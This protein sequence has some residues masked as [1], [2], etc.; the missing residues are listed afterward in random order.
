MNRRRARKA[1]GALFGVMAMVCGFHLY[2]QQTEADV[3]GAA[4]GG[5]FTV[6]DVPGA[7]TGFLEGTFALGINPAGAITGYYQD[8]DF[9]YHGF[10]RAADGTITTFDAPDDVGG[11]F[12]QGINPA[13]T[14]T[15]YYQDADF[16]GHGFLRSP[17]GVITTFDPPGSIFTS[18]ISINPAGAITGNYEDEKT[19]IHGFLRAP[20]GT[21]TTFD[22]P[23]AGTG[24]L[25]GTYASGINPWGEISGC[26]IDARAVG[27]HAFIRA[28]DGALTTFDVPNSTNLYCGLPPQVGAS[29]GFAINPAGAI[30]GNYFEP[31]QGNPYGSDYRGFLRTPKGDFKTFD[32]ATY[33]ACC[34]FTYGSAINP[35]GVIAGFY[36]DGFGV[37]HGYVRGTD[38]TITTLDAPGA[39]TSPVEGE[40]TGTVASAINP[41]GRVAGSYADQ[42]VSYH[43]FLWVP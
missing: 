41:A 22:A 19:V 31:I 23:G 27:H 3:S 37:N 16:F 20:D 4:K 18:A 5:T 34:I 26:Y 39:G 6:F 12:P 28:R 13:G 17:D 21:F 32:A 38:G 36:I 8:A 14:I 40:A 15:G 24:F 11:T 35:A 9:G 29:L 7:G 2:A 1:A 30:T 10:V 25:Q 33:P 42:N 43:G